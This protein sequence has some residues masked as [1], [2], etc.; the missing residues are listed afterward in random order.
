MKLIGLFISIILIFSAFTGFSLV[1]DGEVLTKNDS[2]V[3]KID[4]FCY[5]YNFQ[6]GDTLVYEIVSF[7]SIQ[8]NF[9]DI[10]LKQ[11]LET[12]QVTCDSV[13]DGK[14]LLTFETIKFYSNEL[15]GKD[16]NRGRR[17]HPWLNR[18]AK[19][20]IDSLG[21]RYS[22]E[23]DNPEDGILTPGGAFQPILFYFHGE[24]NCKNINQSWFIEDSDTLV[25]NGNPSAFLKHSTLFRVEEPID[26][27]NYE[28]IRYRYIRTGK[29]NLFLFTNNEKMINNVVINSAGNMILSKNYHIPVHYFAT[30]EQKLNIETSDGRSFPGWHY[31]TTFYTLK[32]FKSERVKQLIDSTDIDN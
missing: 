3:Q 31:I 26:T 2:A 23:F 22:G 32:E 30:M 28:S 1:Q 24:N 18:K 7:D 6:K 14:F 25:E 20:V 16:S 21:K 13:I 5:F 11:R 4:T 9:G 27:L 10:L 17:T 19:I 15:S 29:G 12:L 8:I